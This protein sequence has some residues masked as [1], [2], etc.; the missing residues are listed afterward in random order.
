MTG[1]GW[2]YHSG[3][4]MGE[5]GKWEEIDGVRGACL[6]EKVEWDSRQV[7]PGTLC[8]G[9]KR[10]ISPCLSVYGGKPAHFFLD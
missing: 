2:G 8:L 4:R 6:I 7:R 10:P 1:K 9:M 3:R 5:D